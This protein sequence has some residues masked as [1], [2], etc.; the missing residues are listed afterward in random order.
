MLQKPPPKIRQP[1]EM[2]SIQME[3]VLILTPAHDPMSVE[4]KKML[5]NKVNMP[6]FANLP[7]HDP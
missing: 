5:V 3:T 6:H 4:H 1:Q 2:K 7:T